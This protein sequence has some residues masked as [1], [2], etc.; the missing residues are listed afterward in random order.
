VMTRE[1]LSYT[2]RDLEEL[3]DIP[4]KTA[5]GWR[6]RQVG[7]PWIR[8]GPRLIR[9][10]VDEFYRWLATCARGGGR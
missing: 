5:Q 2:E 10:P 8:V 1:K 6:L 9:Y 3:Y 7:P 4:R